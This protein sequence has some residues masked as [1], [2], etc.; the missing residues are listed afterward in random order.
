MDFGKS[1]A[2]LAIL[3][4][5]LGAVN[6][7][8]T[9]VDLSEV[10]KAYVAAD[11][12]TLTGKLSANVK[13]SVTDGATVTLDGVT[14]LGTD[15]SSRSY[16]GI[17]CKGNCKLILSG[18]N[19]VRGFY[20]NY[21]GIHVP[22]GSTL[23]IDGEG[24]LTALSNGFG[25]GIGGGFEVKCGNIEILGGNITATGGISSA[26]I[27]SGYNSTGGDILIAGDSITAIGGGGS[28]AIGSGNV[29]SCGN[30]TISG[31]VV[32]ATSGSDAMAI[33]SGNA[34]SSCGNILI[35]GGFISAIGG[36]SY[37]S[38]GIGA[39]GAVLSES[40]CGNI[41]ILISVARVMAVQNKSFEGTTVGGYKGSTY[42]TVTV[43]GVVPDSIK[44][45]IY[46]FETYTIALHANFGSDSVALQN[47]VIGTGV[48]TKLMDSP[49][50]RE[51]Y[52]FKNWT[53]ESDGSGTAY[54]QNTAMPNLSETAGD[55]IHLYAQ[56]R[57]SLT[58]S[59]VVLPTI[60]DQLYTGS[61]ITPQIQIYDGETLL[62]ENV[63]YS[64][65]FADNV[66]V[67]TATVTA[68]GLEKYAGEVI[69]SFEI[70]EETTAIRQKQSPRIRVKAGKRFDLI[71]RRR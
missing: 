16:A 2:K 67:G 28:A 15:A 5:F 49:F 69:I 26:A 37:G 66:D 60:G 57:K 35:S 11:G 65:S 4:T 7:W 63:D 58:H 19:T 55:T 43:A 62:T 40:S 18:E 8:A 6:A 51:G 46:I 20:K 36:G 32:N 54:S 29:S 59:D 27:G 71:G 10:T 25:A 64:L 14:I 39:G 47:M 50:N 38:A 34:G 31:G 9:T 56:W 44:D 13:I 48:V 1:L 70:V 53:T 45:S 21:P 42:G 12:D 41:D 61:A 17:N 22:D 33:G 68:T 3:G 23:V 24:S 52:T 30:I